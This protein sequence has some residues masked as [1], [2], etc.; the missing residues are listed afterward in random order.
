LTLGEASPRA[1]CYIRISMNVSRF[2]FSYFWFSPRQVA[3][4]AIA[5]K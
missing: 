5:R 2:F 3:R 1:A 4:E